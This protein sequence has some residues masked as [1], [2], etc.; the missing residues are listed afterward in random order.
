M[1]TSLPGELASELVAMTTV[2]LF[3]P[4]ENGIEGLLLDRLLWQ[5]NSKIAKERQQFR[6]VTIYSF[7]ELGHPSHNLPHS[8]PLPSQEIHLNIQRSEETEQG[9]LDLLSRD[10][11]HDDHRATKDLLQINTTYE[12]SIERYIHT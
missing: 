5:Q 9:L 2:V 8:H 7:L 4:E 12:D 6:K 10:H 11:H 1:T 3:W